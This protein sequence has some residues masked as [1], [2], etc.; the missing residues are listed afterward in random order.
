MPWVD[1]TTSTYNKVSQSERCSLD[2]SIIQLHCDGCCRKC[3]AHP[4][5]SGE[6][7]LNHPVKRDSLRDSS[8]YRGSGVFLSG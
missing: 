2:S 1:N 4:L 7:V 6:V 8:S 3:K 5:D